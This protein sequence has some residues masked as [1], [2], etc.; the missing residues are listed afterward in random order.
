MG[1]KFDLFHIVFLVWISGVIYAGLVV[2]KQ[3]VKTH[4][5]PTEFVDQEADPTLRPFSA[6]RQWSERADQ[7]RQ[8]HRSLVE[9][10][11]QRQRDQRRI[12]AGLMRRR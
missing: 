11:K 6:E 3:Y 10:Y 12:T 5:V 2:Y 4:P 9:S 1:E 7:I 8:D